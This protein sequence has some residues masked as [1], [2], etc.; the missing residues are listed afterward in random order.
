MSAQGAV[1]F[2]QTLLRI[3]LGIILLFAGISHLTFARTEF[4][5]QV[6]NWVPLDGDL[7]VV[8]SGIV[9]IILGAA[10]IFLGRHRV[11]VGW[12]V[13][14][15]F[16]AIFPGNIAQY[17]NRI[18][19]FMLNTDEARAI[20]LLF[21]PVLVAWALWSTGALQAWRSSQSARLGADRK[22]SV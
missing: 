10:L 17:L 12:I 19:A 8:L 18:D 4:L 21:Q 20:R 3:L 6:P 22:Q 11:I 2:I 15:F 14:A 7:V 13:A 16:V 5:A 1:R 9:E